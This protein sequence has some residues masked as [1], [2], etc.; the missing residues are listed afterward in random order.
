MSGS[1]DLSSNSW[2]DRGSVAYFLK[3]QP[4][5]LQNRAKVATGLSVWRV[6]FH[7]HSRLKYSTSFD[8][9]YF[10][11][12]ALYALVWLKIIF[13]NWLKNKDANVTVLYLFVVIT[14]VEAGCLPD[15]IIHSITFI[16]IIQRLPHPSLPPCLSAQRHR[17]TSQ[18]E[19]GYRTFQTFS[20][21]LFTSGGYPD[22]SEDGSEAPAA[23]CAGYMEQH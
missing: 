12:S 23:G 11:T 15:D 16:H 19:E 6:C 2:K 7:K 13:K 1:F 22:W 9:N 10:S 17:H 3:C 8:H 18:H 4:L 5:I 20:L 21:G 14:E